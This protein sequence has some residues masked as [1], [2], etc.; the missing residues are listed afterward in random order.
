MHATE[1]WPQSARTRGEATLPIYLQSELT[2]RTSTAT[3]SRDR[4][5]RRSSGKE[6]KAALAYCDATKALSSHAKQRPADSREDFTSG[7]EGKLGRW[8]Q[9][10]S[11]DGGG[12]GTW[13]IMA[14]E[15]G[16]GRASGQCHETCQ[17]GRG[18][19][20]ASAHAHVVS[21]THS[22]HASRHMVMFVQQCACPG[23]E[24]LRNWPFDSFISVHRQRG[25][26]TRK[27]LRMLA[28]FK[29]ADPPRQAGSPFAAP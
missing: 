10:A 27:M 20:C 23:A 17:A 5:R 29:P 16:S 22:W 25:E 11:T 3:L 26:I 12:D 24:R 6:P 1:S 21:M 9:G 18:M 28:D 7:M 8:R 14:R 2:T 13:P 19:R 15:C 4:H